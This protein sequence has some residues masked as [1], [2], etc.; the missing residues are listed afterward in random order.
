MPVRTMRTPHSSR[1]THPKNDNSKAEP[2]TLASLSSRSFAHICADRHSTV[3]ATLFMTDLRQ[4]ASPI[5]S[6]HSAAIHLISSAI[7]GSL[8]MGLAWRLRCGSHA[9]R[10]IGPVGSNRN[11]LSDG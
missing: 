10:G 4:S 7:L 8:N 3:E 1:A 9:P 5:H 2:F 6:N 11:D